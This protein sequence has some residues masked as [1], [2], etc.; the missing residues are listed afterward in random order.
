[1]MVKT[2]PKLT[3][4]PKPGKGKRDATRKVASA[5]PDVATAA[6]PDLSH[7]LEDLRPLAVPTADLEF[8]A[9]N[10]LEHDEDEIEQMREELRTHG[11]VLPLVVNRRKTPPVIVGGNKRLRAA[12]AEGWQWI[13]VVRLDLDDDEAAAWAVKLNATQGT[14]WNKDLLKK[15]L[16]RVG[17]MSLGERTEGLFSRLAEAQKLIPKDPPAPRQPDQQSAAKRLVKCPECEHEFEVT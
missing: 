13:A 4:I 5:T 17:S 14:Q 2:K 1:M 9:D 11:Q 12:L 15:A 7:I 10:P 8:L 16:N 3:P 6:G